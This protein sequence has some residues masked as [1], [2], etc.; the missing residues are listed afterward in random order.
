MTHVFDFEISESSILCKI[1]RI[2]EDRVRLEEESFITMISDTFTN[3]L[4][5]EIKK[6]GK[7]GSSYKKSYEWEDA[8][9]FPNKEVSFIVASKD[10]NTTIGIKSLPQGKNPRLVVSNTNEQKRCRAL[11]FNETQSSKAKLRP[12]KK[13]FFEGEIAINGDKRDKQ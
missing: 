3:Y 11:I 2:I 4:V 7:F 8:C 10:D 12:G 13:P 5:P 9:T 1:D 6:K